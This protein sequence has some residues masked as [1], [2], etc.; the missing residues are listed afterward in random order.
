MGLGLAIASDGVR[1]CKA[2][3]GW[4][5]LRLRWCGAA[6]LPGDLISAS[7]L[8]ENIASVGRFRRYLTGVFRCSWFSRRVQ[9]GL[10]DNSVRVRLLFADELPPDPVACRKYL[11]W[12]LADVMDFKPERSRLA[13]VAM[14]SPLRGP[15]HAI[16]C[17]VSANKVIQQYER[18]F[19]ESRVQCRGIAP[20]S[21]LLFNLFHR[22][23]MGPPGPPVLLLD[24]T[25]E[26]L[27]TIMTVEGC[28]IFWRSHALAAP[29]HR[30]HG[31]GNWNGRRGQLLQDICEAIMYGDAT[32]GLNPPTHLLVTG[33]LAEECA[34]PDWLAAQLGVPVERLDAGR[35][36][37]HAPRR[38]RQYGWQRWGVALGA[39]A[40]E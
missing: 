4:K 26:A 23:L 7:P 11:L 3:P 17:A 33:P 25:E 39:A 38:L 37:R 30:S 27:T 22:Q 13:Y 31:L 21:V 16:L 28:P 40:R 14:E 9:V 32:L 1:A 36:V 10:P 15:R 18:V 19:A 8:E 24:A 29:Q 35:L 12:R 2:V 5:G 34:F 20:S 6:P